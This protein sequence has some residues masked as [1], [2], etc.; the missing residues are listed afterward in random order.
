MDSFF[1]CPI[2]IVLLVLAF[3]LNCIY[4]GSYTVNQIIYQ[5]WV[6]NSIVIFGLGIIGYLRKIYFLSKSIV[7]YIISLSWI[8]IA[9]KILCPDPYSMDLDKNLQ[10]KMH[11]INLICGVMGIGGGLIIIKSV[12]YDGIL[13]IYSYLTDKNSPHIPSQV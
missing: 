8:G 13:L 1:T 12:Y 6:A 7:W 2:Y 11:I 10:I 3:A 9:S 4:F 5:E